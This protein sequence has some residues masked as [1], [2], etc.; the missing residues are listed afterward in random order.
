MRLA[1][2]LRRQWRGDCPVAVGRRPHPGHYLC[3]AERGGHSYLISGGTL[4]DQDHGLDDHRRHHGRSQHDPV[5][6]DHGGGERHRDLLA[7][8]RHRGRYAV[9]RRRDQ[10]LP[11]QSVDRGA[12]RHRANSFNIAKVT[13]TAGVKLDL[14]TAH[15]NEVIGGSGGDVLNASGTTWNVFIQAG[16]GNN[17]IIGGAAVDAISGGNGNDVIMGGSGGSVIHAGRGSDLIY[18]GSGT[19]AGQPNTDVIFAGPGSDIVAL[20]TNKSEVY[21]GAGALTVIGKVGSFSVIGPARLL[22]RLHADA[23]RRRQPDHHRPCRRSGWCGYVQGRDGAGF[24]G[25][26]PGPGRLR[27]RHAGERRALDGGHGTSPDGQ[28][29]PTSSRPRPCS[30][31]IRIMPATRCRSGSCSTTTATRSRAAPSGV[32]NGGTAA[33]SADGS[34]ITFTPLAGFAGG[35]Q[36]PLP[37]QG[38]RRPE[39]RQRRADRH[40]QQRRDDGDRLSQHTGPADRSAVR[41]RMVPARGRR[42]SGLAGLHRPGRDDRRLRSQ[43]QCR[44]Q[45]ARPRGECRQLGQARRHAGRRP[46]RHAQRPWSPA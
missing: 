34:T 25:R 3:C 23:Q 33:L 15:L 14:A 8:R 28:W 44:F 2:S 22:C 9:R 13:G 40:D 19:T 43:R 46:D 11:R 17:I 18:G 20:G 4:V 31:T 12:R 29:V 1:R 30:R 24:Q 6:Y 7:G 45:P 32:V 21:A 10:R 42:A 26:Q 39:R 16:D 37:R 35:R 36:L 41:Q 27:V 5:R 38:Q